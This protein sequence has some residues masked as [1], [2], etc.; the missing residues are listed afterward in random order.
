MGQVSKPKKMSLGEATDI[1]TSIRR[2]FETEM[3]NKAGLRID[4]GVGDIDSARVLMRLREEMESALLAALREE[5]TVEAGWALSRR[6]ELALFEYA[7]TQ[8]MFEHYDSIN[9]ALTSIFTTITFL[10]WAL[11]ALAQGALMA[12]GGYVALVVEWAV[13]SVI[14]VV[15]Y[16]VSVNRLIIHRKAERLVE[17][18]ADLGYLDQHSRFCY[19]RRVRRGELLSPGGQTTELILYFVLT[20]LGAGMACLSILAAS[21][22]SAVAQSLALI[23]ALAPLLLMVA[24]S[25]YAKSL[26]VGAFPDYRARGWQRWWL[27]LGG[28]RGYRGFPEE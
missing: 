8:R 10:V 14:S 22:Q 25:A 20:A 5:H 17:L 24:W 16:F 9:V 11:L 3:A 13:F 15:L 1:A 6:Q 23:V 4:V 28:Y 27:R 26:V 7:Q 2:S 21:G 19:C 18:E 12:G